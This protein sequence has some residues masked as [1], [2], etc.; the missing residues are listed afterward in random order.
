L[1]LVAIVVTVVGVVFVVTVVGVVV[2][3]LYKK[4]NQNITSRPYSVT[5]EYINNQQTGGAR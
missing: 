1:A 3:S 2:S 5:Y 4:S